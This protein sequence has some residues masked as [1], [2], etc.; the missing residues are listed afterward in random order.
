MDYVHSIARIRAHLTDIGWLRFFLNLGLISATKQ[1]DKPLPPA[2]N[3]CDKV[4]RINSRGDGLWTY[5]C[6]RAMCRQKFTVLKGTFFDFFQ[7]RPNKVMEVIIGWILKYTTDTITRETEVER[8][9]VAHIVRRCRE[10]LAAWLRYQTVKIGG[11]HHT[12]EVDES[13]FGRRK[14]NRGRRTRVKWVV[15]GIDRTTKQTFLCMAPRGRRNSR[16]LRTI[17][18]RYVRP[19]TKI[20]TD[21]W[22]AYHR[23]NRAGMAYTHVVV[24]HRRNMV[25]PNDRTIHTQNI[26]SHWSKVKRSLRRRIGKM[27]VQHFE[28]YLVEYMWRGGASK[29]PEELFQSFVD[30]MKHFH[31]A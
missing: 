5:R 21:G 7:L 20:V 18:Q 29:T 31:P 17:I 8:H 9:T 26:E 30:A 3:R 13:A 10:L 19:F 14:Y 23:L 1:C 2:N 28:T 12:V 6:P 24:N 11:P 16:T 22:P 27:S 25:D 4:C 15:G